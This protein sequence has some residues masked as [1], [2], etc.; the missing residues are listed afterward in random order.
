MMMTKPIAWYAKKYVN[1]F[2]L[3]LVPIEPG[4]KF[5]R[6]KNWGNKTLSDPDLADAFYSSR[7]DWNMGVSLGPSRM[8][9]LDIDC[10][11]SFTLICDS[12]GIDLQALI[13]DTP[14]IQGRSEGA[15]LMFRVPDGVDLP[16]CKISWRAEADPTGE[17]H[18]AL[19][20][21][22]R[23][24]EQD[25]QTERAAEVK[26]AARK[27]AMYTVFELRSA[28][29]GSQRQD[30]LPPSMHPDTGQPYRWLTQPREDWPTPPAWLLQIWGDPDR[31][32]SQLMAACPWVVIDEVYKPKQDVRKPVY[33]GEGQLSRVVAEYNARTNLEA[34][35]MAYG[36]ERKGSRYLSPHSS[37]RLPGVLL[38]GDDKCW[39]HHAS[40]PLCSEASGRP[41]SAFDLLCYYDHNN[42][43]KAAALAAAAQLG[44]NVTQSVNRAPERRPGPVTQPATTAPAEPAGGADYL[45]P[46][47]WTDGRNKPLKHHENLAEIMRRLGVVVRYNVIKKSEELLIPG[48]GF[49]E[50]NH[51]NASLAWLLSECSVFNFTTD[52]I[53]DFLTLLSD[54]NPYNP[55]ATWINS[56]PWDGVPRMAELI[57]T[58]ETVPEDR[59]LKES[60][61][62]RWLIS[63]VAAAFSGNGISARGVLVLQGPQQMG[64][65][66]WFKRLVPAD[67][68]VIQDGVIL[69]PDD[70]DSVKQAV[71]NWIV[72][73]GELDATFKKTDIAQLKAFITRDRD[74]IRM[75]Y[76]RRESTLPRRTV[77]FGSVNPREF[78]N[79]HTGNTRFWTIPCTGINFKHEID[80]QQCWAEIYQMFLQGVPY[81]LTPEE[82]QMLNERNID[83][84]AVEP[85]D[86]RIMK[87]LDWQAP[88]DLWQWH[89]ATD[90]LLSVGVD[91]P[92][93]QDTQK[94]GALIREMNGNRA[95]RTNKQRLLL[96]PPKK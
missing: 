60:L 20:Q 54:R 61:M 77:F 15:R 79:D 42:D 40:D 63:A 91:R 90:V 22:A 72:E 44:I 95:R 10:M 30:V 48:Q 43:F 53:Q 27:Y 29:D 78:L 94:A 5:P 88:L 47:P 50:D 21:E 17:T 89:Q 33:N 26:E 1:K 80:M 62:T 69:K 93:K 19:M 71:S 58:I 13:A 64:K 2:G 75:P 68:Q 39:I 38:M 55:V 18:K 70:K 31:Y 65:T 52:A 16:Y 57:D 8:C 11:R 7:P 59:E 37:T 35:L 41:V 76:A 83:Y 74:V 6:S 73:L 28:T 87:E 56:K 81:N 14:T 92:T 82:T 34:Q 51:Q 86:E 84:T 24:L 49:S 96:V 3:H 9:S 32:R 25:G 67:L 66:A 4:R 12:F 45:T 85:V 23:E 46:L 36:Y